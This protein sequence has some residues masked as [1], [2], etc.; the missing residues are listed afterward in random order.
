MF[1]HGFLAR[2][3]LRVGGHVAHRLLLEGEDLLFELLL[4]PLA[5]LDPLGERFD[6]NCPL[7]DIEG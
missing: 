6:L 4:L 5:I 7:V 2:E 1:R 3:F